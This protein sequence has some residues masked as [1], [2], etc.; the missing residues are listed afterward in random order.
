MSL[1]TVELC[2]G[3]TAVHQHVRFGKHA[4]SATWSVS[5]FASSSIVPLSTVGACEADVVAAADI[6]ALV[7]NHAPQLVGRVSTALQRKS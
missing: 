5:P 4:L 6:G 1:C 2:C 3:R 7:N